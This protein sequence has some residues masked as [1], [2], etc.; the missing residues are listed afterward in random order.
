MEGGGDLDTMRM[1]L[2]QGGASSSRERREKKGDVYV[3]GKAGN[4]TPRGGKEGLDRGK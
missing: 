2:S 1:M 4:Q 3:D